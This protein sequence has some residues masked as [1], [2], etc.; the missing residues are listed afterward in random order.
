MRKWLNVFFIV[1]TLAGCAGNKSGH[2][3]VIIESAFGD[4]EV[5]LYEDKAPKTVAAFL[6]G[7]DAGLYKKSS[8]YRVL[9]NEDAP[10]EYNYGLIQGGVFESKPETVTKFVPHESPRQTGISHESGTISMAR[11]TPGSASSEFF[12]CIGNQSQF[13]SS[14][15]GNADGLGYAAFG[16]VIKGMDI[17]KAI[18]NEKSNGDRF[19][20]AIAIKNIERD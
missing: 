20:K 9:K 3:V 11:T 4:I 8:F 18:Q 7:I 5:E 14:S 13:D 2:P 1:A 10:T 12:I 6:A 15:R 19:V 16:R 17:V